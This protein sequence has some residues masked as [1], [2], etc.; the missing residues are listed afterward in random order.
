MK[1]VL[2]RPPAAAYSMRPRW[3]SPRLPPSPTHRHAEVAAVDPDRVVGLVAHLGVGLGRALDVGA[4]AAVPQQV[5]GGQ[6]DGAHQLGRRHRLHAVVER[7]GRP[8]LRADRDRLQ[9]PRV[10]AAALRDHGRVVV[11]PARPRQGEQPLP[12]GVRRVGGRV[13]VEEDVAVVEGGH[14]PGVLGEQHAVAEHVTGH[15]ADA[16]AGELLGLAVHVHL[17]E[18]PPDGLPRAAGGDAHGLVVV[19][20]RP[21]GRERVTEPEAVVLGDAVGDVGERRGA[22]VG[23]DDEVGVV[24]VVA[25]DAVRRDGLLALE[26]V[27]D[28]EQAGDERLVAGDALGH[29]LV[30]LAGVGQLL[31]E[32]A[33]LG[34]DRHDHG[35]LDHLRLDQAEHLR[36]EV[37]APVGP[38][39]AAA[40]HRAEPQVHA[41]D[42]RGVDEDL[43]LGP[44]LGQVRDRV[45]LEL[46]GD[47]GLR[48]ALA[49]D[50]VVVRAQGRLDERQVGPQDP[51]VVEAGDV[52]EGPV[53]AVLDLLGLGPPAL[54]VGGDVPVAARVEAGLEQR[55]QRPGDVDVV[56]EG[57]LDVVLGERG[58]AL[59]HVLRVGAQHR[60]LPPGHP[61]GEDE[62]VEA[63]DLVVALPHRVDR[64]LEQLPGVA[65]QRT[66]VAQAEVVDVRLALE[67]VEAVGPL[68][69]HLDAHRGQG[70]EH[71]RQRHRR[72]GAEDLEPRLGGTRLRGLVEGQVEAA[73]DRDA[74]EAAE[75]DR[76]RPGRVVLLV[77]LGERVGVLAGQQ[78]AVLLAVLRVGGGHEVVAPRAC[79]LGEP[80]LEVGLVEVADHAAGLGADHEV[81]PGEQRLA[82]PGGV[83]QRRAAEPLLEDAGDPLAHGGRVAVAGQVDQAGQVAAV[84]VAAHEEPHLAALARVEHRLRDRH[85]LLDR[86][87]EQLVA[88]VGL[89]HVHERLAGVAQRREPG[90]VDDLLGLDPDHRDAGQRL[91]V[92]RGREQPQEAPLADDLAAL[93]E[94]LDTDVVEVD[95]PVHGRLGV[96]LGQHQQRLLAGLGPDQRRQLREGRGHVLVGAQD[97]EPGAGHGPQRHVVRVVAALDRLEAVLAVAQEREVGV[98]EP[99][100][101][102]LPLGDLLGR[103]RRRVGVEVV[104]DVLR[105]LVHLR[106]V[107]DGLP[108]VLEHLGQRA[109]GLLAPRRARLAADL[110][111][112]PRLAGDVVRQ[113]GPVDGRVVAGEDLLEL[114]GDVAADQDLRVHDHVHLA[115]LLV[116]LHGHG[117]HEERHVIGDHLDDRVP[118]GGP[119]VLGDGR[120]EDP[121]VGGALGAVRRGAVLADRGAVQVHLGALRD[122]L[123]GHVAVEVA[124]QGARGVTGQA[125]RA[126]ATRGEGSGLLDQVVPFGVRGPVQRRTH[127]AS[128]S[129]CSVDVTS[130][131]RQPDPRASTR[132]PP[133]PGRT[134]VSGPCEGRSQSTERRSHRS[135]K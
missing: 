47:V 7:Q 106:P 50:L 109:L 130:L 119:A 4:D 121:D 13:R 64:V 85:E 59:A 45:R 17:A 15:V 21:A 70:R 22:L 37:V 125:S 123:G 69:D 80:A 5:D 48:Q 93:V 60:R 127:A 75:V 57:V 113:L 79:R 26:V 28:V 108:D 63:V 55:D 56:L 84:G 34:A 73:V 89:E 95:R 54:A 96:G 23:G 53:D 29:P 78:R 100:Q 33:A 77:G 128:T 62:G 112:H 46:E 24:A 30:A 99:A 38:A 72:P 92:G 134:R 131:C 133:T 110:D 126:L 31:A 82:D 103:Q 18:V 117:V 87:L 120:G 97:P 135:G 91:R 98:R 76:A 94:R 8:D 6:Q 10:D 41:L 1:S 104:D 32:E 132:A 27:G 101:Q 74:L 14:Q 65:G 114:A 51:V 9:G 124:E 67:A 25:H 58:A 111:V 105:L 12:L 107:L 129:K 42:P 20:D 40:G 88:G 39:Q 86:G 81:Q 118:A 19:A 68:V 71:L 52:V 16:D 2:I 122:V 49:V 102:R 90:R 43:E 116:E 115:V 35:V 66:V 44:R 11:L 83:L 3:V 61:D 36:A